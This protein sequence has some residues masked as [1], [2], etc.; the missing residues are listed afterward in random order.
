MNELKC[1]ILFV[2]VF[3]LGYISNCEKKVLPTKNRITKI[4]ERKQLEVDSIII[5]TTAK[6]D[7]IKAFKRINY[8]L[9]TKLSQAKIES[10]TAN[11]VFFQDSLIGV[12]KLEIKNLENI[13]ILQDKTIEHLQEIIQIK[14]VVVE[15]MQDEI[16]SKEKQI[17]K[18]KRQ[19]NLSLIGGAIFSG[20]LIYILK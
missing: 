10:D 4:V 17:K 16:V 1:F 15:D 20:V 12:Q 18:F 6:K 14:D 3:V 19:R 8:N 7:K 9:S 13:V 5:Q 11:I 2:V